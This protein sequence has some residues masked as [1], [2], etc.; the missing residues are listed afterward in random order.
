MYIVYSF[1]LGRKVSVSLVQRVIIKGIIKEGI[2][3][4]KTQCTL[5]QQTEVKYDEN[6]SVCVA[7][8]H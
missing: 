5:K 6:S 3:Y 7:Q 8:E 2:V 1:L 4:I